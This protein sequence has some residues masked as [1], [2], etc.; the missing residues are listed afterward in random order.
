[1]YPLFVGVAAGFGFGVQPRP[2]SRVL[3]SLDAGSQPDS[4]HSVERSRRDILFAV[5]TV[6]FAPNPAAALK[7]CY[8]DCA[9]NCERVANNPASKGY[10]ASSCE[11]YCF[12][13]D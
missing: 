4:R 9:S 6:G 7:D 13:G 11:Y 2:D 8:T 1:M 3:V 12:Q 10:C 5:A